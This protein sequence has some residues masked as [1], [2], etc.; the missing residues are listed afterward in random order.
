MKSILTEQ[1]TAFFTQNGYIEFE[2]GLD[3]APLFEGIRKALLERLGVGPEKMDRKTAAEIYA[4]GRDLWRTVAS[5]HTLLLRKLSPIAQTLLGKRALRFGCDQWIPAGYPWEKAGPSKDLFSI[6]GLALGL[7][8]GAPQSPPTYRSP[9]GLLPLPTKP[10]NILF[11][12]P[13][14]ILDWPELAS[15]PPSDLYLA[16]YALP[17]AVYVQNPKDP[18]TNALK[19]FGYGFGDLLKN[20]F[21]PLIPYNN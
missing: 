7:L 12:R 9:L 5:L 18:S 15:N 13:N 21:H 11:F 14:L 6:Q 8:I 10:G 16:A 1:Q 3:S 2:L 4:A 19:Q 17:N 20:E